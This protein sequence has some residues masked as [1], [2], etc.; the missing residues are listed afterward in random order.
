MAS[1]KHKAYA[2][3]EL[4]LYI[5][6]IAQQDEGRKKLF[7]E[8]LVDSAYERE[9]LCRAIS[10]KGDFRYALDFCELEDF[11][12]TVNRAVFLHNEADGRF[13]LLYY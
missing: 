5:E 8:L 13:W 4:D 1:K 9:V 2:D 11:S 12:V 3:N 10:M 7:K 6:A